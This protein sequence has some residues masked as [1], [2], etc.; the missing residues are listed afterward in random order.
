MK[1][2]FIGTGKIT[3]A[4]VEGL[5][6]SRSEELEIFLSPRNEI[7]LTELAARFASVI[8]LKSNQEVASSSEVVFIALRPDISREVI[9]GIK[10]S[11]YHTVISLVPYLKFTDVFDSLANAASQMPEPDFA[12][13][14]HHAAT[15][16]RDELG[17]RQ[18]DQIKR[19]P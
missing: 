5:C 8:R 18:G 17:S 14:V 10:F 11:G 2:G 4:I 16:G 19:S 6:G 9:R 12:G 3:R 13:L 15:P 1:I 7:L